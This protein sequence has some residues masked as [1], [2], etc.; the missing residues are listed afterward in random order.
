MRKI[1][2][3]THLSSLFI[4]AGTSESHKGISLGRV[5]GGGETLSSG[6]SK[7][8]VSCF[9]DEIFLADCESAELL[10]TT[11]I[12]SHED[13]RHSTTFDIESFGKCFPKVFVQLD[14]GCGIGI[15]TDDV[16]YVDGQSDDGISDSLAV[17]VGF[18]L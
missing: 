15:G 9:V 18:N 7:E 11:D 6:G 17:N 3:F 13:A 10:V 4:S 16:V 12:D 8:R 14:S 1:R 5:N 2:F